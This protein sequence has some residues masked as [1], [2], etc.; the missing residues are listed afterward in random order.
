MLDFLLEEFRRGLS[1]RTLGVVRSAVSSVASIEG[2]PAGQHVL[3]C[4]FMR[5]VFNARPALPRYQF[6]WDPD[7]V[8]TYLTNL[9]GND[10][11]S[12]I[13]MSRKL[14]MLMLLQSGQRGQTLMALDI[15][16]MRASK[17]KISFGI[18]ELLKTSRPG[19]HLSEVTF[20]RYDPDERLC[21]VRLVDAYL[22]VTAALR[23]AETK[24]L[25]TS[26]SPYRPVSRDTLR[27]WTGDVLQAA[28]V[29]VTTFGPASTRHAS[30]SKAAKCLPVD[31]IM[32]A[33]GWT[34]E[35]TFAIYYNKPLCQPSF[36]EAVMGTV[37]NAP[38]VVLE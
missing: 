29:D 18:G 36:S 3:V 8:L 26:R 27:R 7:I 12:L 14:A 20:V 15:G 17:R 33:V 31:V 11:L 22:G 38:A 37:A 9:G 28:G 34:S 4:R 35:S 16:N 19:H 30:S 6:T 1:Y 13:D 2:K 10:S 32:D 24:L 21:V 25:I 5:S 23:G